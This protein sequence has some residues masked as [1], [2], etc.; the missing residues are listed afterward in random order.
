MFE[1]ILGMPIN[2]SLQCIELYETIIAQALISIFLRNLISMGFIEFISEDIR[3][4]QLLG[5]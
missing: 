1:L 2:P 3:D 4:G 5:L